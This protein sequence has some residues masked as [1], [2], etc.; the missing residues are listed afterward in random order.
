MSGFGAR[1]GV[2][3][4][5]RAMRSADRHE[6]QAERAAKGFVRGGTGLQHG[7]T[8]AAP[9]GFVLPGSVGQPLPSPL[10]TALETAFDSDLSAVRVH[11]DPLA[12]AAARAHRA[13]AFASG[14][15]IYFG[16]GFYSP[17]SESGRS[18]VAH[19]VAH[20]LQQ[21]ATRAP[22]GRWIAVDRLGGGELQYQDDPND[23]LPAQQL[24]F[25]QLV[26]AH[27]GTTAGTNSDFT[28]VVTLLRTAF[29]ARLPM[30][31]PAAP[32]QA[33]SDFAAAVMA[34]THDSHTIEARGLIVDVLKAY[35]LHAAALH[36]IDTDTGFEIRTVFEKSA[37]QSFLLQQ[38]N[39][40]DWA[41]RAFTAR[42]E[43]RRFWPN[44]FVAMFTSY[45]FQPGQS[46]YLSNTLQEAFR[47]KS[48]EWSRHTL[49]ADGD[50]VRNAW[51]LLRGIDQDRV[52]LC[53]SVE[54][55]VD[56]AHPNLS[57]VR[58]RLE[59]ARGLRQRLDATALDPAAQPYNRELAGLLARKAAQAVEVYEP[60]I[61]A[62]D[63]GFALLS[64]SRDRHLFDGTAQALFGRRLDHPLGVQ[65]RRLMLDKLAAVV[66]PS[67]AGTQDAP[68]FPDSETYA[69]RLLDYAA[70]LDALQMRRGSR[71]DGSDSG[72]EQALAAA[73][74]GA[75][76]DMDRVRSLALLLAIVDSMK[77]FLRTYSPAMDDLTPH[78]ADERRA[79][80]V[81]LARAHAQIGNMLG[82]T[83]L[84]DAARPYLLTG[85]V[86]VHLASEWAV[87]TD[88]PMTRMEGDFSRNIDRRVLADAPLTI[89]HIARWF[90][91]ERRK[92]ERA[93]LFALLTDENRPRADSEIPVNERMAEVA[94]SRGDLSG[95]METAEEAMAEHHVF[96]ELYLLD[97]QRFVVRD[98][99]ITLPSDYGDPRPAV[100]G[101]EPQ[102]RLGLARKIEEHPK[103]RLLLNRLPEGGAFIF[104]EY[105]GQE[106]FCWITP[107][108][109]PLLTFL[110]RSPVFSAYVN[111]GAEADP[112]A[113]FNALN[114]AN[115]D[116]L[117]N[118]AILV[119][120]DPIEV[121]LPLLWRRLTTYRRRVLAM[122]SIERLDQVI[123]NSPRAVDPE[124]LW[125]ENT[126]LEIEAFEATIRPDSDGQNDTDI[127]MALLIM[128]LA[129]QLM[130][131]FTENT[132]RERAANRL[133]QYVLLA[134]RV[135]R[136][137]ATWRPR[138]LEVAHADEPLRSLYD[139]ASLTAGLFIGLNAVK[140]NMEENARR[141]RNSRGFSVTAN[142]D[143]LLPMGRATAVHVGE[144]NAWV[145]NAPVVDGHVDESR[146][147]VHYIREIYEH[148]EYFPPYG[149]PTPASMRPG[150]G[151]VYVPPRL[152]LNGTEIDLSTPQAIEAAREHTLLLLVIDDVERPVTA[153]DIE[154]LDAINAMVLSRSMQI[155][156]NRL[157]A[158]SQAWMEAI[159]TG[160]QFFFP[161]AAY[162]ETVMNVATFVGS[163]E[164]GEIVRQLK[165]DPHAVLERVYEYV[166]G[167]YLTPDN[168]WRF[169]LLG[170]QHPLFR[171]LQAVGT[172]PARRVSTSGRLARVLRGL[173]SIGQKIHRA[174]ERLRE[175]SRPPLR[176]VQGN[177]MQRPKLVW[178]LHRAFML[179][180]LIGDL[181]PSNLHFDPTEIAEIPG[182]LSQNLQRLV[183]GLSRLEL[184]EQL[185][186]NAA[187]ISMLTS[188]ALQRMG[189][190]GKVIEFILARTPMVV[191]KDDNT[192]ETRTLLD[193]ISQVIAQ[194]VINH[195]S[196]DPNNLWRELLPEIQTR[197][198]ASRDDLVDGIIVNVNALFD[199][200]NPTIPEASRFAHVQRPTDMVDLEIIH[201]D[202]DSGADLYREPA[203]PAAARTPP[204]SR[205]AGMPLS[206]GTRHFYES[207]L[208]RDLSHVRVHGGAEGLQATAPLDAEALTSG[209]HVYLNPR[210]G[211]GSLRQRRI[212]GHELAHVVQQ[213]GPREPGRAMPPQRGQ[214]GVGIRAHRPSERAADRVAGAILA[215]R[216]VSADDLAVG[217]AGAGAQPAVSAEVLDRIVRELTKV[218]GSADFEMRPTAGAG[219][220]PGIAT[221]RA[222]WA[223]ALG[224]IRAAT[225]NEHFADFMHRPDEVRALVVGQIANDASN[226]IDPHIA[227]IAQ[228]A[229]RPLAGPR[230]DRGAT[231]ELNPQR[232]VTLLESFIFASRGI[233]VQLSL[234]E[235]NTITRVRFTNV[236]LAWVGGNHRL[237]TIAFERA[238]PADSAADRET[239]QREVRQLLTVL[240]PQPFIWDSSEFKLSDSFKTRLEE[241]R[242]ARRRGASTVPP[243]ADYLNTSSPDRADNLSIST[244][245][246]LT[247]RGIGPFHRESHHTTQYLLAEFF[248]NGANATQIAFPRGLRSILS[249]SV[250]FDS[251]GSVNSINS[252]SNALDVRQLDPDSGRGNNMPA[253]LLAATTHQRGDLHVTPESDW[254]IGAGGAVEEHGSRTQ[255]MAIKNRFNNALDAVG[256]SMRDDS[257]STRTRINSAIRANRAEV[258]QQ[259][260][261]AAV[262]TYHWMHNRMIDRLKEGLRTEERA[263]YR[264]IAARDANNLV[265]PDSSELKH[266]YDLTVSDMDD[267]WR[268]ARD[269][270]N[271]VMTAAGW[272]TPG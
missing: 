182:D 195:S 42:S 246:N 117:V 217:M 232:F 36:L 244:H 140:Q 223:S 253:I 247:R 43:L 168:I 242:E 174:I 252:G 267:V 121:E 120:L 213:T 188:F 201:T 88:S 173:R 103:T 226:R 199:R 136:D 138:V 204:L 72:L 76:P 155:S 66:P 243:K 261:S 235:N 30:S 119:E 22:D 89:R 266:A 33:A 255:G 127:Q 167:R 219:R 193:D 272:P 25:N 194:G 65:L 192:F 175:Y 101:G 23:A 40:Q 216:H 41:A 139:D 211:T 197:F 147:N 80:A 214:P 190:R 94:H 90:R 270:N 142:K 73:F 206:A 212:L 165:D 91:L 85:D 126:A 78:F 31:A 38:P 132:P 149:S 4:R 16:P 112:L 58:R 95:S 233:A 96:S 109:R 10:R 75:S 269:N 257:A 158:I 186:D 61:A 209:S 231:T 159:V 64:E 162:A 26:A 97:P 150:A 260:Y 148:F 125:P 222:I 56:R 208:G 178:I 250:S 164:F 15:H 151:G 133:Y 265:S 230:P 248:G 180:E 134:L 207:R 236:H 44:S 268:R 143:G 63:S 249:P 210:L 163:D 21:T 251:D 47:Q 153:G 53:N 108:L 181:L 62:L 259:I 171:S 179:T 24:R 185:I 113:W 237:W 177:L 172:R 229:Q 9:A 191:Q 86:I 68:N 161:E 69:A 157:A 135:L 169:L 67:E 264:G 124:Y 55:D 137:P 224:G 183:E 1:R 35:G 215:S 254:R 200:I 238:Y 14:A 6:Q 59:I 28:A 8:S 13:Q 51:R 176:A 198:H 29:E 228:L 118:Q 98:F 116:D 27:M 93:V 102:T 187:V 82:W 115:L 81:R 79:H 218:S 52:N 54:R 104:P 141:V 203:L 145:R 37:F 18:L 189:F 12:Q 83:E 258:E 106:M 45:L 105:V 129:P 46:A 256:L 19:E 152:I 220:V 100:D 221:A 245:G 77:S 156:M 263:Y 154:L 123:R 92:R 99:D 84:I 170:G 7:L 71:A 144:R 202:I 262:A 3:V 74:Q 166:R 110:I 87:D 5:K 130:G 131:I 196:I 241:A 60:V 227:G 111:A 146:G 234:G 70:A 57:R 49:S 205:S 2:G 11:A 48:E 17:Q 107:D 20:V 114:L 271:R 32:A 240:G 34:G 50:R 122:R 160:A 39:G 128:Q 184:P 225:G 239:K